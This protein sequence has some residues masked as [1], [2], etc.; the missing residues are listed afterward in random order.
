[1]VIV[2][3]P[4]RVSFLGGG[5]DYP[6][7]FENY[8]G[9]AVLSTGIDYHCWV[10]A[11][12]LPPFFPHLSRVVYSKTEEV[13]SNDDITHPAVRGVLLHL[14][15][16]RGVE[17][18]YDGDLPA[19]SG[20]GSSSAFVVSLLLALRTLR[21]EAVVSRSNLWR[22]A[23]L[24]EREVLGETVGLQDQI[25]TA[26]GGVRYIRFPPGGD[27]EVETL[28]VRRGRIRELAEYMDLFFTGYQRVASSVAAEQVARVESNVPAL[29][30]LRDLV[31]RG[32]DLVQGTGPLTGFGDLLRESWE[33]K[34]SLGPGVSLDEVDIAIERARLAGATGWKILGAGG[35]GF[36]LVFRP[37]GAAGGVLRALGE[38][39]HVPFRFSHVGASVLF[40]ESR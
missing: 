23:V 34:K 22:E 39:T 27:P 25:A 17:I 21:G 15:I 36:L 26:L 30:R 20:V 14:G 6:E 37:P 29:K 35:G 8:G 16:Q 13:G 24:V 12:W 38:Y 31:S 3:T 4:Y 40:A 28:R 33:L 1:M 10:S 5:T 32:V 11:R 19:R 9:G 7:F 18:H 2:R